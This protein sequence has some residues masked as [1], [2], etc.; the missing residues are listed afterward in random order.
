MRPW[1]RASSYKSPAQRETGAAK[2]E[3]TR[4]IDLI[5]QQRRRGKNVE[6][7]QGKGSF[8]NPKSG[9]NI[10]NLQQI[11]HAANSSHVLCLWRV[12]GLGIRRHKYLQST[13]RSGIQSEILKSP[14]C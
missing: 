13:F 1:L 9:R 3:Q 4:L 8:K 12:Q 10:Q 11:L 5:Q 14:N 2:K 7:R 6:V